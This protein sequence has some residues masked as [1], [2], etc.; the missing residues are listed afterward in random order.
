[1][2][3]PVPEH[4]EDELIGLERQLADLAGEVRG[5]TADLKGVP[6]AVVLAHKLSGEMSDV[7]ARLSLLEDGAAAE[8]QTREP[9]FK[10]APQMRWHELD[11]AG[12]AE[13]VARISAWVDTVYRQQFPRAGDIA[14]CWQDHPVCVVLLDVLSQLH[15]ALYHG[16]KRSWGVV[17]NQ[18][19]LYVRFGREITALVREELAG[20]K[21]GQHAAAPSLAG[22]GGRG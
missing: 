4:E 22:G 3:A 18:A 1:V 17:H 14:P 20:C 19:E 10:F 8:P 13:A 12:R 11:E 21:Y 7:L 15:R 2:V 6:A 9:R 16:T 5:W